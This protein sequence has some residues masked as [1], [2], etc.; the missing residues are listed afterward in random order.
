[1]DWKELVRRFK[2][3]RAA[4]P[5]S[6]ASDDAFA[7][8]SE[9]VEATR[10]HPPYHLKLLLDR[11][12]AFRGDRAPQTITVLDHGCGGALS[13]FYLAILGY[14]DFRGVD[15]G[16][17]FTALNAIARRRLGAKGEPLRVY[18][19]GALPFPDDS[20]D[21]VFSQQVVEHV[22]D[23]VLDL[24]YA[25]EGR[26]LRPGGWAVH[27]VPHR[28]VPFDS[29]TKTWFLHYLPKPLY[30]AAGRAVGRP[31]PDHLHLRWPGRHRRLAGRHIGPVRDLTA[32]RFAER[33]RGEEYD[34]PVGVRNFAGSLT[35]APVI[36]AVARA[37]LANLMMLETIAQ[38][39]PQRG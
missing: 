10:R 36:G 33:M 2:A 31:A 13:L 20:V 38:K 22:T 35:T 27:Y 30:R 14:R 15:I 24:Y 17:D 34:G 37:A 32:E 4:E 3:L 29:H 5:D 8:F 21:F 16:G 18:D 1:M 11:L 19:G 28:L 12:D 9:A 39:P 7:A 26:V 23:D 6:A 25:E